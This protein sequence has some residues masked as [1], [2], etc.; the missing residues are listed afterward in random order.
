M[1]PARARARGS[2]PTEW[3]LHPGSSMYQLRA[4]ESQAAALCCFLTPGVRG[5]IRTS[6]RGGEDR[7]CP[8]GPDHRVGAAVWSCYSFRKRGAIH[9][10]SFLG[11][12][13]NRDTE[14]WRYK[15]LA[16]AP[17]NLTVE[18][19]PWAFCSLD[20]DFVGVN[21]TG[22]ERFDSLSGYEDARP[23]VLELILSFFTFRASPFTCNTRSAVW[24]AMLTSL[25]S[26][27][28]VCEINRGFSSWFL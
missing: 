13:Q 14:S 3:L 5:V 11:T 16:P 27:I 18:Y 24:N 15:W 28:F 12:C 7:E 21:G 6:P 23:E 19:V 25:A 2:D 9:A 22:S 1:G 10:A 26:D 20:P 4:L 8:W 17:G